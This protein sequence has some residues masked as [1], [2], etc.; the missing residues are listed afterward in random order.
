MSDDETFEE[1][2]LYSDF[3]SGKLFT[4]D[5]VRAAREYFIKKVKGYRDVDFHSFIS[6]EWTFLSAR[7]N[8]CCEEKRSPRRGNLRTRR[9]GRAARGGPRHQT[10]CQLAPSSEHQTLLHLGCKHCLPKGG[11]FT[12]ASALAWPTSM[13]EAS[14]I[15]AAA[16]MYKWC[17]QHEKVRALF[18][19]DVQE[20]TR[21]VDGFLAFCKDRT[22]ERENDDFA[23]D[24]LSYASDP[25]YA[26][27]LGSAQVLANASAKDPSAMMR[28]A[29]KA[30]ENTEL[31]GQPVEAASRIVLR[32]SITQWGRTRAHGRISPSFTMRRTESQRV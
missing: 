17:N 31:V 29:R 8:Q 28:C 22:C 23:S 10:H 24:M 11:G 5:D 4:R 16:T 7:N 25:I 26:E 1:G 13:S 30:F 20:S 3:L 21:F 6:A 32:F 19:K 18:E 27:V 14:V 15:K 9:R 2:A 12:S